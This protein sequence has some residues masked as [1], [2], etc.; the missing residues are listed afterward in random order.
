MYGNVV[1]TEVK[2]KEDSEDFSFQNMV[3]WDEVWHYKNNHELK[4]RVQRS[5]FFIK[6]NPVTTGKNN[7]FCSMLF[8]NDLVP[9][10]E[11]SFGLFAKHLSHIS[12]ILNITLF[13]SENFDG[14]YI[15]WSRVE[16]LYR[17]QAISYLI[18]LCFNLLI[19]KQTEMKSL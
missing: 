11:P 17:N 2:E 18:N 12:S 9:G 16:D 4:R 14:I 6:V 7:I 8:K 5:A 3:S 10:I 1:E 19:F 15:Q 13:P